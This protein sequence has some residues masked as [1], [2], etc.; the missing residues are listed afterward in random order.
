MALLRKCAG[1]TVDLAGRPNRKLKACCDLTL[2]VRRC[3]RHQVLDPD[4]EGE[5]ARLYIA[6]A[7]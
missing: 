4:A 6:L 2:N 7:G 3:S 5:F 1:F